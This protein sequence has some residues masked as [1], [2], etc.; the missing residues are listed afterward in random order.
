M[1]G[2]IQVFTT[3]DSIEAAQRIARTVVERRV[4]ACAQVM[5]PITS[6]YWWQG[7]IETAEEW[8]CIVK[9]TEELYT[10]LE[11]LIRESHPYDVPEILALPVSAGHAAYLDW[12]RG[13]ARG[14]SGR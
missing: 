1:T 6:T 13:E 10:S 5:G 12:L 4:A 3:V 2:V 14:W 9:S 7:A 11:G 8:L